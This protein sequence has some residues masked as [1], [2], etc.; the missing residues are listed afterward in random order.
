[1]GAR[2]WLEHLV[3][4]IE[5]LLDPHPEQ[6]VIATNCFT[7]IFAAY[8]RAADGQLRVLKQ[9]LVNVLP[10]RSS[11]QR[12]LASF[13]PYAAQR[14]VLDRHDVHRGEG[15]AASL[16]EALAQ[17]QRRLE[18]LRAWLDSEALLWLLQ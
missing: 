4:S 12:P 1:M 13:G 8:K 7:P 15:P 3:S 5:Q 9:V 10:L 17:C 16:D 6:R 2:Q 18:R 14:P 11:D